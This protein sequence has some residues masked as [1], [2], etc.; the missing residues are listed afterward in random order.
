MSVIVA[1]I[2][3]NT[4]YISSDSIRV[5][6]WTKINNNGNKITKLEEYNG[7]IIGGCGLTEETSLFFHYIKTHSPEMATEKGILDFIINF[8]KWKQD[9]TNDYNLSNE[10][11]LAYQ[12][13]CF[14]I[15]NCL[16]SEITDYT[17]IGAGMDY[18]LGALH[19]GATSEEAV[20]AACDLCAF[21]SEPIKT[22]TMKRELTNNEISINK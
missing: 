15:E 14:S 4:I 6:G 20:K 19:H 9:F 12:G 10:Y 16:V 22:K 11:I 17:A 8:R 18:A 2:I 1:K 3:D 21:V 7:L 13:K 5:K